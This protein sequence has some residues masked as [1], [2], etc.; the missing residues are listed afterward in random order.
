MTVLSEHRTGSQLVADL[1]PIAHRPDLTQVELGLNRQH[2]RVDHSHAAHPDHGRPEDVIVLQQRALRIV[3]RVSVGIG[4]AAR[5]LDPVDPP[6]RAHDVQR[7][8]ELGERT[9]AQPGPVSRGRDDPGDRLPVVAAHV[10]QGETERVEVC[11][12]L[13]D[14]DP[15]LHPHQRG[16]GGLVAKDPSLE[17][18]RPG[19]A[20]RP[21]QEPRRERNVGPRMSRAHGPHRAARALGAQHDLDDL[22]ERLWLADLQRVDPLV[23]RVVAPPPAHAEGQ[24]R[25]WAAPRGRWRSPGRW[26]ASTAPRPLRIAASSGAAGSRL[27]AQTPVFW[28]A[29]SAVRRPFSACHSGERG[30]ATK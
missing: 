2:D 21:Q 17:I 29:P 1:L 24:P 4:R 14:P 6:A 16:R 18:E 25:H 28:G 26:P 23:T 27:L 10:G 7:A 12:E 8:N 9:E 5:A 13:A 30:P 20:R 11:V 19:E 15:R 3:P 22:L